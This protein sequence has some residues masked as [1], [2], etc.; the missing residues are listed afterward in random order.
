[1]TALAPAPL[2][3]AAAADDCHTGADFELRSGAAR[4]ELAPHRWLESPAYAGGFPGPLLR[5]VEGRPL[6]LD[7]V[8]SSPCNSN[9]RLLGTLPAGS[10]GIEQLQGASLSSA[11][12]RR[13]LVFAPLPAGP[14][15]YQ[16]D[17]P[18]DSLL[19][20]ACYGAQAGVLLVEPRENPGR[21]D[22]EYVLVLK[23]FAPSLQATPRGFQVRYATLTI[24]GRM[25]GHG[26]PLRVRRG[27][28]VLLHLVNASASETRRLA[29]PRHRFEVV[30]IDGQ[31]LPAPRLLHSVRLG[32]GERITALVS[33]TAPG[34]WMLAD[35]NEHDRERGM[36]I[37]VEYAGCSGAARWQEPPDTPWSYGVLMGN[38][39]DGQTPQ[40]NIGPQEDTLPVTI[41]QIAGS[42]RGGFARWTIN[43][44]AY[45]ADAPAALHL[46]SGQ[47][48]RLRIAND[49]P[50]SCCL[51]LPAH[52]FALGS[53]LN[54]LNKDVLLLEPGQ[55]LPVQITPQVPGAFL[56]HC[57]RQLQRTFGLAARIEVS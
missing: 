48:T 37:V 40:L 33:M 31:P 57:R 23:E 9:L 4:I 34:I 18:S 29:L 15:L 35:T 49:T 11:H 42:A 20:S 17:Q 43:G 54:A 47:V 52:R 10:S 32:A 44:T 36:G 3:G 56:L 53:G 38:G 14:Y 1:M 8:N 50:G 27:E 7:V 30:A 2:F 41:G 45:T 21:Y 24:N 39:L 46:R 22:R 28:R 6:V 55:T 51:H 5:A 16:S 13:R 25:S 12:A 19:H 26:E